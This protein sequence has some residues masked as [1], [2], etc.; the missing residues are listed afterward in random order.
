[1]TATAAIAEASS[2]SQPVLAL[3]TDPR[4]SRESST[5]VSPL[6]LNRWSPRSFRPDPVDPS[7]LSALFEAARWAPSASNEQPWLFLYATTAADR[8]RFAEGL[9]PGNRAWAAK[10]PALAFLLARRHLASS[11]ATVNPSASF[12]SGA[13]WMA[14]AIQA[15][16]LGLSVHAMGG[17]DR[18]RVAEL[19][20]VPRDRFE[21][22][23]GIAIGHRGD[24]AD[25]PPMLR[26]RETPSSRRELR[27]VAIEGPLPEALAASAA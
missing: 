12:D 9:V 8:A 26:E 4:P 18:D 17:I 15:E 2:R 11:P 5:R 1:M 6:F 14:L 16:L 10:A 27:E 23:V 21:I 13:A 25:L 24:P 7:E 20:R 3:G 22:L 19:L